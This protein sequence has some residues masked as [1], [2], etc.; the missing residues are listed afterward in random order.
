MLFLHKFTFTEA[1]NL[2]SKHSKFLFSFFAIILFLSFFTAS[3]AQ[4]WDFTLRE[5]GQS[6]ESANA[7]AFDSKGNVYVIGAFEG[8]ITLNDKKTKLK[9]KGG[10]DIF[11][12]KYDTQGE[13][14]WARR[15]GGINSDIGY[16]IAINSKDEVCIT[17][18]FSLEADF[19]SLSLTNNT[20]FTSIF[21]AQYD[22]QGNLKWVEEIVNSKIY[23]QGSEGRG[24][25]FDKEDNIFVT[26]ALCV[27]KNNQNEELNNRYLDFFIAKYSTY[28][29]GSKVSMKSLKS[30]GGEF[31]N[32]TGYGITVD[33]NNVYFT[34][35]YKGKMKLFG[36]EMGTN[37]SSTN[38]FLAAFDTDLNAKW[39]KDFGGHAEYNHAWAVDTDS[40]GNI[41]MA[42]RIESG[43][44][45]DGT[46]IYTVG[47]SDILLTKY[48]KEGNLIWFRLAGGTGW[49]VAHALTINENDEIYI[50]G[51]FEGRA[52]FGS[53]TLYSNGGWD[54]FVA[55]Y[56]TEGN[57]KEAYQVGADGN[58]TFYGLNSSK[59]GKLALVGRSESYSLSI[60][61]KTL[62]TKGNSDALILAITN[63]ENTTTNSDNNNLDDD[64]IKNFTPLIHPN[65]TNGKLT[66]I[67]QEPIKD[68]TTILIY[69]RI[70]RFIEEYKIKN[71]EIN[72]SK[73]ELSLSLFHLSQG[74]YLIKINSNNQEYSHKIIIEK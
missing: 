42:G 22:E 16:G 29:N 17:G 33:K 35:I 56:D 13:L 64:E 9:S 48:D 51:I 63:S 12:A 40:E 47:N 7:T 24:I 72:S 38:G 70:G 6:S 32:D 1:L 58:D 69:D 8:E 37:S 68:N 30:A 23:L 10:K 73:N 3:Y 52:S 44:T 5:G 18:H 61:G 34:G 2:N 54:G 31:V 25:A 36:K 19:S 62:S 45:L 50:A 21:I 49:D 74:V 20:G 59:E 15:A 43:S 60:N 71:V 4:N 26:G 55:L 28:E 46:A 67:F 14:V 65:P 39:I 11:L 41:Y 66:I 53:K 57:A 27:K